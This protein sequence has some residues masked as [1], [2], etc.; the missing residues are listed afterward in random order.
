MPTSY[1]L[2]VRG[3][4]DTYIKVDGKVGTAGKGALVGEEVAFTMAVSQDQ[5]LIENVSADDYVVRR[6]TPLECER[7]QGFPDGH[8]DIPYK[9]KEHAPDTPRYKALGNSMAVPCMR[10]IGERMQMVQDYLDEEG[11]E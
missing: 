1:V 10:W 8:T 2:K 3:G 5:T 4:S 11:I 9:N 6:L 7:L